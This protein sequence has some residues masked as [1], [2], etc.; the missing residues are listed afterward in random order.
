VGH[1]SYLKGTPTYE[2]L[3]EAF[4]REIVGEDGEIDRQKLGRRVFADP[5]DRRRLNDIVWPAMAEMMARDLDELRAKGSRVAVLEAAI[6][7]EAGWQ[8]LV[9]EIWVVVARP[10]TAVQRLEAAGMEREQAE[11]RIRS[12]LSNE[13]RVYQSDVVIEND[14]TP[15]ELK[16]RVQSLWDQLQVR[17]VQ[18]A[19]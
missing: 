5:E 13:E 12:Q 19:V 8:W 2:R 3:I 14:G 4:G 6:L 10:E 7:I 16:A 15:A 17:I 18:H 9:D 11:A 1:R